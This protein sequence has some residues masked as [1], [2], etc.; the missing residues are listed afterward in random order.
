[1]SGFS[2][3]PIPRNFR[4]YLIF[5][6]LV[7]MLFSATVRIARDLHLAGC[8]ISKQKKS[9]KLYGGREKEITVWKKTSSED[10]S[11]SLLLWSR[12]LATN[13]LGN[14]WSSVWES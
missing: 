6:F 12:P 5:I 4:C 7:E 2:C 10:R 13:G 14:R 11:N 8:Q 9:S 1:M 3:F